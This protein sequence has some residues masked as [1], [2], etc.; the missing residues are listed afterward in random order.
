M[1]IILFLKQFYDCKVIR[2]LY[3]FSRYKLQIY[4]KDFVC[5]MTKASWKLFCSNEKKVEEKFTNVRIQHYAG[6]TPVTW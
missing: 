6:L 2:L 5:F 3:N 1:K 4:L